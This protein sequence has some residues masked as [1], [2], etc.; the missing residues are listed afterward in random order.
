LNPVATLNKHLYAC[1][2]SDIPVETASQLFYIIAVVAGA[3]IFII[4][5]IV[6]ICVIRKTRCACCIKLCAK[7]C[8]KT[9]KDVTSR[10][11]SKRTLT[12]EEI[13]SSDDHFIQKQ[14][15][16]DGFPLVPGI[17]ILGENE[18][19]D[20]QTDKDGKGKKKKELMH[21]LNELET[22]NGKTKDN[23]RMP[24]LKEKDSQKKDI[25]SVNGNVDGRDIVEND[26]GNVILL[27]NVDNKENEN[28]KKK[29]TEKGRSSTEVKKES[30]TTKLDQ[31]DKSDSKE[32]NKNGKPTQ[33]GSEINIQNQKQKQQS[34]SVCFGFL[35]FRS[36][37][38]D[39]NSEEMHTSTLDINENV[40]DK[41]AIKNG[42]GEKLRSTDGDKIDAK[43][44][45]E[46]QSKL[47]NDSSKENEPKL[48]I[49]K[50]NKRER[51]G[52]NDEKE[53]TSKLDQDDDVKGD[54]KEINK[55]GEPTQTGNAV[56][57]QKQKQKRQSNKNESE[58]TKL[59][60]DKDIKNARKTI[61]KK[62]KPIQT[63]SE[64]DNQKQ[65]QK[66]QSRTKESETTKLNQDEDVKS[67]SKEINKNGKPTQTSSEINIQNQ[68]QKQQSK[69]VCFG[70]LPFHSVSNDDNSEEMHTSTSD[71]NENVEDKT[72]IKNGKGE[73]LRSTDGD[74]IDAKKKQEKQSKLSNDSSKENEPKL[75]NGKKNKR[76]RVGMND[77][78]DKTPKDTDKV[79]S[80]DLKKNKQSDQGRFS[81]DELEDRDSGMG[82]VTNESSNIIMSDED[83]KSNAKQRPKRGRSGDR[84][85]RNG[86]AP[87]V[88]PDSAHVSDGSL[89]LSQLRTALKGSDSGFV[90]MFVPKKAKFIKHKA[91]FPV[92]EPPSKVE[93][94][95]GVEPRPTSSKRVFNPGLFLSRTS[96]RVDDAFNV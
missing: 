59:D 96:L 34:K 65:K 77:G 85:K 70:F 87:M 86:V 93:L 50:K 74:K 32:I 95:Y 13:E 88:T 43:K 20:Y 71:I 61:N 39:D 35:P 4:L 84:Q 42:K 28:A 1:L 3:V 45:Q 69:S 29:R 66:Q 78:K 46:K 24:G 12:L 37:S 76:E 91:I 53:K 33:T 73:K 68:K 8:A 64:I 31:D 9:Q 48:F 60:I 47:S 26:K 16:E 79:D 90:D 11:E 75:F 27:E 5:L 81:V 23:N 21:I 40:E 56:D 19:K 94:L 36:V 49:G 63:G 15:G 30:G 83:I 10:S 6:L 89:D 2:L 51:V 44:K 38:N 54:N 17:G 57:N 67:D 7:L 14:L 22:E 55:N 92:L 80:N 25:S 72:A 52:M 82:D 58:T 18:E 41:T 62:G